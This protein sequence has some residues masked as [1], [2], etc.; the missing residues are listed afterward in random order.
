MPLALTYR[1]LAIQTSRPARIRLYCTAA[2]RTADLARPVTT[3]PVSDTGLHFEFV[4]ADTAQHPCGPIVPEGFSLES[5]PS[6]AIPMSVTNNDGVTGTVT[7]TLL[8]Q[9]VE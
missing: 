6:S 2:A 4:T 3:E 8:Y 1:L 9:R 5:T 7:V